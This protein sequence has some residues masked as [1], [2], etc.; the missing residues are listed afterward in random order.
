MGW[1]YG[2]KTY[3]NVVFRFEYIFLISIQIYTTP[4]FQVNA[5][6]VSDSTG[7]NSDFLDWYASLEDDNDQLLNTENAELRLVASYSNYIE[8]LSDE[9]I[10]DGMLIAY[11]YPDIWYQSEIIMESTK[12]RMEQYIEDAAT[13]DILR[14]YAKFFTIISNFS[15]E[16][17]IEMLDF[18]DSQFNDTILFFIDITLLSYIGILEQL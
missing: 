13:T 4:F 7:D 15:R 17:K 6:T 12:N 11:L 2:E 14:L 10:L 9:K 8:Q 18:I 3:D 1:D 5:L 16:T